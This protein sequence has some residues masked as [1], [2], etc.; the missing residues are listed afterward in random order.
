MSRQPL[1]CLPEAEWAECINS[2]TAQNLIE[3]SFP[4]AS[5]FMYASLLFLLFTGT[6]QT[7]PYFVCETA[8]LFLN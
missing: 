3:A 2:L 4:E 5:F 7:F 6:F 1:P 8:S